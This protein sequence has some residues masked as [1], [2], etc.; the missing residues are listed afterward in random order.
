[1]DSIWRI[2]GPPF[3][4]PRQP[5]KAHF[6]GSTSIRSST[7]HFFACI[8]DLLE[9]Y[10]LDV[11]HTYELENDDRSIDS[12]DEQ[13][14]DDGLHQGTPKEIPLVINTFGWVKGAGADALYH[15]ERKA[16]LTHIVSLE[17]SS[18]DPVWVTQTHSHERSAEVTHLSVLGFEHAK[19]D[20]NQA[21]KRALMIMSYFHHEEIIEESRRQEQTRRRK[22]P[23]LT[24]W[25]TYKPLCARPPWEVRWDIALDNIMLIGSG[26]EDIVSSELL[27]VLNGAIV[28]LVGVDLQGY[29][30]SSS[31]S[32]SAQHQNR[33][34]TQN[35]IPYKQGA[36][37]PIPNI[38]NCLGLALVR[39]VRPADGTLHI[40]TPIAQSL[41][42]QCRTIVIGEI[43]LPVWGMLD[44]R[45]ESKSAGKIGGVD[46]DL[47]PF[48]EWGKGPQGISGSKT[49]RVRR[50]LMRKGQA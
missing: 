1:M 18:S 50:N 21:N 39:S 34:Q 46:S 6:V 43:K 31:S 29:G 48:L 35:Q 12:Q 47:V 16:D 27:R 4:H 24:K 41:L 44:H 17:P 5:F 38:S 25:T 36:S 26:A 8:D 32:S 15:I 40:I 13:D 14:E 11:K 19:Q 28:A 30:V 23:L 3:T 22:Q 33:N 10:R 42:A 2:L 20:Q 49:L 45:P 9:S 37:P 7:S